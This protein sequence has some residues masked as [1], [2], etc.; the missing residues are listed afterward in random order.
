MDHIEI[1]R[2][3]EP[4]LAGL[5]G[6]RARKPARY[7]AF[8][9]GEIA[10]YDWTLDSATAEAIFEAERRCTELQARSASVG[11][12]TVARQLLRSEAVAS[13]KIEGLVLSHR[14]LAKAAAVPSGDLTA[15]SVLANVAAIEA[16]YKFAHSSEPCSVDALKRIHARLFESTP[17]DRWGGVVRDRQNWIGGDATT[18]V[19]A[20]FVPPPE[21]EVLRL[22]EDLAAFSNRVDLPPILQA[23]VAHAQYETIHPFMDGNGRAGRAL[24]SMIL[25]RRGVANDVLP[26]I[27][28]IL[29]SDPAS[30]VRGLTSYRYTSGNDWVDFFSG[31]MIRAADSSEFL[32]RQVAELKERWLEAAREPRAGS[33]PRRLIEAIPTHPVLT[34]ATA[35]SITGLSD[36]ACRRA[37]NRLEQ[38]GVLRET[39]A[40]KRNRVWES[41]GLF[42]LLDR[43]EREVGDGRRAPARTN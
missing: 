43:L 26:P 14:R 25:I 19:N 31:T 33:A 18:P 24:I 17:Q 32:A 9:P 3:W 21:G 28:L 16:A 5:G 39:T 8:V 29:A 4:S 20:D 36:E 27:S 30:Y 15:H 10:D 11:L 13:S 1:E 6:T 41:V 22:L 37:L 38:S 42:D 35:Q 34:L 2:L 12:D 7:R 23:A 40:G